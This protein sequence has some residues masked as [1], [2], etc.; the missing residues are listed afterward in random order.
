VVTGLNVLTGWLRSL[1]YNN[2]PGGQNRFGGRELLCRAGL[3]C[4]ALNAAA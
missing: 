2:W 1:F 4:R 3:S